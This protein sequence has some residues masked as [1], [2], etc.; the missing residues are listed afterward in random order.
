MTP[1]SRPVVDMTVHAETIVW[2]T[3]ISACARASL[4]LPAHSMGQKLLEGS[5]CV[6]LL[7]V[8]ETVKS[9]IILVP[10]VLLMLLVKTLWVKT[11]L[12][13]TLLV[14]SRFEKGG[15]GA[16]GRR[17]G[18]DPTYQCLRE[19]GCQCSNQCLRE[20]GCQCS[21]QCL[22]KGGMT[23]GQRASRLRP[24]SEL[25]WKYSGFRNRGKT[26][27]FTAGAG[28]V[29][30]GTG[31]GAGAGSG[32]G[33]GSGSGGVPRSWL[34]SATTSRAE[35]YNPC[36]FGWLYRA[37]L[38]VG[39][40][41]RSGFGTASDSLSDSFSGLALAL[42][43]GLDCA[44]SAR[45]KA[46]GTVTTCGE[47]F[48]E[49][50][51]RACAKGDFCLNGK[52]RKDGADNGSSGH[53]MAMVAQWDQW[54]LQSVVKQSGPAWKDRIRSDGVGASSHAVSTGDRLKV[55]RLP[56]QG[57][58]KG[59]LL[60]CRCVFFV[61]VLFSCFAVPSVSDIS[62]PAFY[63]QWR[64]LAGSVQDSGDH[65]PR[66]PYD[67]GCRC[68]GSASLDLGTAPS[69]GCEGSKEKRKEEQANCGKKVK[70]GPPG[71][72]LGRFG[73]VFHQNHIGIYIPD[74]VGQ[75]GVFYASAGCPVPPIAHPASVCMCESYKVMLDVIQKRCAR[76]PAGKVM[77]DVIQK[78]CARGPAVEYHPS[79]KSPVDAWLGVA[80]CGGGPRMRADVN[81]WWHRLGRGVSGKLPDE[82]RRR[83]PKSV[84]ITQGV[85]PHPGPQ[86]KELDWGFDNPDWDRLEVDTHDDGDDDDMYGNSSGPDGHGTRNLQW[87]GKPGCSGQPF[88]RSAP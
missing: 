4:P 5:G 62:S 44:C 37:V 61:Y 32:S 49:K 76:R 34:E 55:G 7:G 19:E 42:G 86:L 29:G 82:R 51:I 39:V 64:G 75:L 69:R 65:Q 80:Q 33:S 13:K 15:K 27:L 87:W 3:C 74:L 48:W 84:I 36:G 53:V 81:V 72:A 46:G 52:P 17:K 79:H 26:G 11:L 2:R 66:L 10:L 59:V 73:F 68:K 22:R 70:D 38:G 12:V 71:P 23:N 63:R 56:M 24:N 85:H 41:L 88:R 8:L 18:D 40:H 14:E 1:R 67:G 6:A 47:K 16:K 28:W 43:L 20:E 60:V 21:N 58:R 54:A 50:D 30:S 83:P 45:A 9:C 78:R 25:Q 57:R 31:S 35:R 77:L